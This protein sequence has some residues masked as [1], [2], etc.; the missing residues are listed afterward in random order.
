MKLLTK[1]ITVFDRTVDVSAV[2]A[3]VLL[4]FVMLMV[5]TQIIMRYFLAQ[6]MS[7]V[8][9]IAEYSLLFITFF[10]ATWVLRGEG[11]VKIDVLIGR[12]KPRTQA[13]ANAVT[14]AICAIACFILTWYG[15]KVTLEHFRLNLHLTT[16][17]MPATFAILVIIP[18][19][20]LLLFAQFLKRARS[21]LE[22]KSKTK[23]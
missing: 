8:I 21:Y 23:T 12:F 1:L 13:L 7:G 2:L 20:Y 5:C 11:H 19:G 9:E 22:N 18:I 14:S 3:A 6:P 10:A 4:V 15:V 16:L 17:L